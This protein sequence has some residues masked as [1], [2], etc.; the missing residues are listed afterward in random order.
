[1]NAAVT[2]MFRSIGQVLG[3]SL[4]AAI[5]QAVLAKDLQRLIK[6]AKA[7]EV[8]LS[9][10][11]TVQTAEALAFPDQ[12]PHKALHIVHP[13]PRSPKPPSSCSSV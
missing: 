2:Y 10:R 12:L 8:G 5:V 4:S 3:V 11:E 9:S 1:M 6:G 7:A 13:R